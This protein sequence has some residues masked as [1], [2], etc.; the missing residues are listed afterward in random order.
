MTQRRAAGE[1]KQLASD[2][3]PSRRGW[4]GAGAGGR[5]TAVGVVGVGLGRGDTAYRV[6]ETGAGLGRGDGVPSRVVVGARCD[7]GTAYRAGEAGAGLGREHG[8]RAMRAATPLGRH[9]GKRVRDTPQTFCCPQRWMGARTAEADFSGAQR[10][11]SPRCP[12]LRAPADGRF[13]HLVHAA[14]HRGWLRGDSGGH[15]VRGRRL[16]DVGGLSEVA[17]VMGHEGRTV[18]VACVGKVRSG[19]GV[20]PAVV[21]QRVRRAARGS[22]ATPGCRG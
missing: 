9:G 13:P 22:V 5:H 2:G 18:H 21:P 16:G 17:D 15:S 20:D 8:I 11:L 10:P 19:L 1:V 6:G 3:I 7:G 14:V 12:H 4:R